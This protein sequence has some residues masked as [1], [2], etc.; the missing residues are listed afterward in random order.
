MCVCMSWRNKATIL[1]GV[2]QSRHITI[3][4][5][6]FFFCSLCVYRWSMFETKTLYNFSNVFFCFRLTIL[7]N[8]ICSIRL[9]C[10]EFRFFF[11]LAHAYVL[12]IHLK[13]FTWWTIGTEFKEINSPFYERRTFH[14]HEQCRLCEQQYSYSG[15][16]AYTY[17]YDGTFDIL[18]VFLQAHRQYRGSFV[19]RLRGN[20][21]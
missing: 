21:I 2:V 5:L 1:Q 10:K 18:S 11:S 16:K 13:Q 19:C 20:E 3:S 12:D 6:T 4:S 15:G 17:K 9:T 7:S 14:M 8:L